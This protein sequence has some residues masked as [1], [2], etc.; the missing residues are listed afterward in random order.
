MAIDIE[1]K[2]AIDRGG[3]CTQS[4]VQLVFGKA[5]GSLLACLMVVIATLLRLLLNPAV[6]VRFPRAIEAVQ[7]GGRI[8]IHVYR[9][10]EWGQSP[11]AQEFA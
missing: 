1:L 3:S 5:P 2:L 10:L 11:A 7:K 8:V 4:S 9:Y 6:G